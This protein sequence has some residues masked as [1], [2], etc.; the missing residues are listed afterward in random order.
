M[1]QLLFLVLCMLAFPSWGRTVDTTLAN[2]LKIIV[3]EDHRVPVAVSQLWYRAG[4]MD[5]E[6]G[7]TG[8]AHMLEHMMFRGT[9]KVPPGEFSKMIANAGGEDNAFTSRDY[10]VYFEKLEKSKLPLAFKLE[11]DR[12][13]NL[14]LEKSDFERELKVVKEERRWRTD[15]RPESLMYERFSAAAY[16]EHPYRN[17]VIGWRN[18]LDQM[19]VGDARRWY[20]TWY[21]PN[22]AILVVAGDVKAEEVFALAKRYFGGIGK[23]ALPERKRFEE[24]KQLGTR[25]VAVKA[26]A[27]L[28][29]LVMGYHVPRLVDLKGDREPYALMILAG[30]LS[31]HGS[32]R[33]NQSLVR[34]SRLAV[35]VGAD[36]DG[37]SRGP[38]LFTVGGTPSE[39]RMVE[40]LQAGIRDQLERVKKDGISEEEL[41]RVKAQVVANKVYERDSVFYQAM[42]LGMLEATGHSWKDA[43]ALVAG[44]RRVTAE[45]VREVARKYLVEDNLT[46]AV[47]DP[48][49]LPKGQAPSSPPPM[50]AQH[51]R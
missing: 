1:R 45:E 13:H 47:L 38:D 44:L 25:K 12:M 46:V 51:V 33:L 4:A 7:T 28:P 42:L 20:K 18:D 34:E 31:G 32:A 17:P 41:A 21:T 49:P 26:P 15:D 36:Y 22:N 24:P 8:V 5:E 40:E 10:T 9:P 14:V 16:L 19:T 30:V 29:S 11:A 27:R 39:G 43:D 2:G 6:P 3:K 23:R 35:D 37:I 50:G 48:Q